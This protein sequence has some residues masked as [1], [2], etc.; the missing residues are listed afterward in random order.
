MTLR[1]NNNI[2]AMRGLRNLAETSDRLSQSLERLSS[3]FKINKGADN[4]AGLVISEQ[5]RAQLAGLN[6]AIANSE[7]DNSMIQTTEGALTE[8]NGL[9]IRIRQLALQAANEGANDANTLLAVQQEINNGLS[10]LARLAETAQFGKRKLL[11]GTTGVSGEAQG[12]GLTFLSAKVTTQTSPIEG[13]VVNITQV[14][15]QPTLVGTEG[16]TDQS[17][18]DLDVSFFEGGKSVK[19]RAVEG[20]TAVSFF[21]KLKSQVER[22]GLPIDVTM[23]EDGILRVVHREWGED[24]TFQAVSSKPGILSEEGGIVQSPVKG[25]DIKGTIAG[26]S[27]VGK[28]QTLIGIPGNENTDGLAVKY[29][30]PLVVTDPEGPDG[31]PVME[32]RPQTGD[33]GRI[34]VANNALRFQI[35]PDATVKTIVALPTV[36][37]QFLSR[38]VE[39]K[40]GFNSLADVRVENSQGAA[41]TIKMVDSA[42]NELNV[43][44]GQLGAF[45]RNEVEKNINSLRVAVENLT[46]AESGIRDANIAEE[47]TE[48]TK[49]QIKMQATLATQAQA[50]ATPRFVIDLIKG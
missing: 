4:P 21:G 12:P 7:L 1:I 36:T 9:L 34:N 37:P 5:M 6:Q 33:V 17:V 3:G 41:D 20:D 45:Q 19:V 47:V 27:T 43:V 50:N 46:A 25:Q 14:P 32:R 40:S 44:R 10:S 35:V 26:E 39:N 16:V 28:G 42:I 23:N 18:K 24:P 30:G 31:R 29:S 49:S 15:T 13:Y 48:A 8:V 22:A 2:P 38:S 11:D